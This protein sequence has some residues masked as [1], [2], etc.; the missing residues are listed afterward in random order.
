MSSPVKIKI[1]DNVVKQINFARQ[2]QD[3]NNVLMCEV[4]SKVVSNDKALKE[5]MISHDGS[6]QLCPCCGVGVKRQG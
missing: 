6:V 4:C 5:H 2:D 1:S 3:N